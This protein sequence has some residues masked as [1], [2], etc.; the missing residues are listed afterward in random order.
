MHSG[1]TF[2]KRELSDFSL[3]FVGATIS[4]DYVLDYG[5]LISRLPL[6]RTTLQLDN[7]VYNCVWQYY[8]GI[9]FRTMVSSFSVTDA[10]GHAVLPDG[11]SR[12]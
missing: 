11:M 4:V 3:Q 12:F 6:H 2:R 7:W 10:C 1:A 5:F 9:S 8:S